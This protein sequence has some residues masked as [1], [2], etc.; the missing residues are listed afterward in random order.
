[1]YEED[2]VYIYVNSHACLEIYPE[3]N[4]AS[5]SNELNPPLIL[6]GKYVVGIKNIFLPNRLY[7]VSRNDPSF[8]MK[9]DYFYTKKGIVIG[10]KNI[11]YVPQINIRGDQ[12]FNI[13]HNLDQDLRRFLITNGFVEKKDDDHIIVYSHTMRLARIN[14]IKLKG[15][16]DNDG[17][18]IV[19]TFGVLLK[20]LLG[21]P[22]KMTFSITKSGRGYTSPEYISGIDS[23]YI[24]SDI[25]TPSRIGNI[26]THIV[27]IIPYT[28]SFSKSNSSV[29]YKTLKSNLMNSISITIRDQAGRPM[30]F[31]PG[32]SCTTILHFKKIH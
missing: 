11:T 14:P 4:T 3:N 22:E 10:E 21:M 19:F 5:F 13:I 27:D 15:T 32:H 2:D 7:N 1:M 17:G 20:V 24:Y 16:H 6:N 29:I 23:I 8:G 12:P 31:I 25:V 18:T 26:Q 9:I 30:P 28:G